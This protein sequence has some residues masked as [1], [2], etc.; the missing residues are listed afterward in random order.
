MQASA[1]PSKKPLWIK[2]V[3]T[4]L[5]LAIALAAYFSLFARQTAPDVT[6][7]SLTGEQITM[8]SLRGKVVVVNFWATSCVTCVKEMPALVQTYEKYK[9]QGLDLIA[10]AMN[11]DPPN[12]VV[13]FAQTRQLPFT[14][15]LD[16]TGQVAHSFN[17][18]K[19]TPTTYVIGKD[20]QIIKR[21]VGE[22]DFAAFHQ[23][24]E[25]ALAA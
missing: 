25:K 12:Y 4:V 16:H 14:V 21:Y 3:A 2:L 10:V 5:A 23:L 19:L 13:N 8:Q 1:I 18:V 11:Y 15:A 17:D 9:G 7:S 24:I 22:P 20:G 6:F